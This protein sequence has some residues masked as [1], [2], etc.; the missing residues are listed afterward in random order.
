MGSDGEAAGF[1]TKS[2]A[3]DLYSEWD[4]KKDK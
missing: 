3:D 4:Q 2:R 1:M